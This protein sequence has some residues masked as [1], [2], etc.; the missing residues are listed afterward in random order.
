MPLLV[1]QAAVGFGDVVEFAVGLNK[2]TKHRVHDNANTVTLRM[3][4][5]CK[6]FG[7]VLPLQKLTRVGTCYLAMPLN[8][9]YYFEHMHHYIHLFHRNI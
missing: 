9:I 3:M 2:T 7:L 1:A 4:S 6:N 8:K 5:V